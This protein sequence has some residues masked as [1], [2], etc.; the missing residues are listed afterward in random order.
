MKLFLILA[1]LILSPHVA[2]AHGNKTC[3]AHG[4]THHCK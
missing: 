2:H 4:V 1:A 3:H